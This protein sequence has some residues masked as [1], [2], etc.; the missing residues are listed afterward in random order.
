LGPLKA[1]RRCRSGPGPPLGR[2]RSAGPGPAAY[3][4]L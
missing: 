2:P 1:Q 4:G 3:L